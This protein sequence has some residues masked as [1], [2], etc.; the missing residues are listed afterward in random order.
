M[1]GPLEL[2]VP[3]ELVAAA[4]R[5]A[6]GAGVDA[7]DGRAQ[8]GADPAPAAG[9]PA[10]T[11]AET[12]T[13]TETDDRRP[14]PSDR[15]RDRDRDRPDPA[16]ARQP[17]PRPRPPRRDL[18]RRRGQLRRPHASRSPTWDADPRPARD[19]VA[20]GRYHARL[21]VAARRGCPTAPAPAPACEL[22]ADARHVA[23][24]AG[25][26]LRAEGWRCARRRGLPPRRAARGRH[27]DRD[28][29]VRIGAERDWFT[30]ELGVTIAGRTV[31]LLPILLQA[32]R[33]GEL[34][35]GTD[36]DRPPPAA[37]STS[38]CPRA[39]WSTCRPSG[40]SAGCAPLV[41][42]ELRGARRPRGPLLRLPAFVAAA[43]D[44]DAPGRF[45][46]PGALRRRARAASTR[47]SRWRR[48]TR[49]RSFAGTLRPYQRLGL[50]WLRALHDAGLGG[51]LADE[52]GLGKTVQVLAFLDELRA[53]GALAAAPALVV[54]PR[55]VVGNWQ[56]E[57]AALRARTCGPSSTSAPTAPTDADRLR[58]PPLV[59][60]SYQTLAARPRRCSRAM[61]VDHRDL[62]RGPGGQE[63]RHPAARRRRRADARP[64]A[65]PSPA[66]RSRTTSASCGRSSTSSMPGLLGRRRALRRR[67]SAA[68]SRSTARRRRSS[69]CAGASGPSCCAGPR[70]RSSST[71]RQDRDRRA[72]RARRR[73]A[74]SL[75]EPAPHARR[76]R[77]AQ[78]LTAR[79][80]R[81]ARRS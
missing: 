59:I 5:G 24:I 19:L 56:R 27:L 52:M 44:D 50:A 29:C 31:P 73:A 74:R 79:G 49:A 1:I 3:A 54:A 51:L 6:A 12:E 23:E 40:C 43:L 15:D 17:P 11:P 61:R 7:G 67:S 70:S 10:P 80:H 75:R 32:I 57:A 38:G 45:A 36:G 42:L 33:D 34:V 53:A 20:E 48:A 62:R 47:C 64:A 30:L 18:P 46:E 22:L 58:R 8:P 2:G 55:S 41:E 28:A 39:S 35:L 72:D 21:A 76:R 81:T 13:E 16:A 9:E 66:R 4:D 25:A 68:R 60:T 78:A 14:R 65:S 69:T 77:S 26:A 63:P 37:A 71:C